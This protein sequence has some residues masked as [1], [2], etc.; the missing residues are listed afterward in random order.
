MQRPGG[1]GA[2][3]RV[4]ETRIQKI[5]KVAQ[6]LREIKLAP[7]CRAACLRAQLACLGH[8]APRLGR[9]RHRVAPGDGAVAGGTAQYK[10]VVAVEDCQKLG[11]GTRGDPFGMVDRALHGV[12]QRRETGEDQGS[13]TA[14][15][16]VGRCVAR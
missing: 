10:A 1:K 6:P 11:C 9:A 2:P 8:H 13:G 15:Q 5:G 12:R 16:K 3:E 4:D 14:R 7:G